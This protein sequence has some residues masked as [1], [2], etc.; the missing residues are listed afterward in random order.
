MSRRKTG[1]EMD[2]EQRKAK[3]TKELDIKEV[4]CRYLQPT[5]LNPF[6]G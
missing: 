1:K 4:P 6:K 2:E 3:K 5:A